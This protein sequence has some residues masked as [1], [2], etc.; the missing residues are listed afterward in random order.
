MEVDGPA[1]HMAVAHHVQPA[2]F[3]HPLHGVLH[4]GH[5]R[6][7]LR[8]RRSRQL[9]KSLDR[10]PGAQHQVAR[11]G[12]IE[13]VVDDPVIGFKD[14]EIGRYVQGCVLQVNT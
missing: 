4:T 5:Q 11:Q 2:G 12:R 8:K 6:P 14:D 10:R 7:Q 13:S 3:Q 1:R 9:M